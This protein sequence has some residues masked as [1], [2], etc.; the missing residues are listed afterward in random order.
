MF[1]SPLYFPTYWSQL[2]GFNYKFNIFTLLYFLLSF[3]IQKLK[4]CNIFQ[5]AKHLQKEYNVAMLH[6]YN[7]YISK[8]F[9]HLF[10]QNTIMINTLH[11]NNAKF[12]FFT[13]S[14]H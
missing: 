3:C 5:Q 7:E 12:N 2:G 13:E 11:L 8:Q 4:L 9:I 6:R 10:Q 14:L 1:Y